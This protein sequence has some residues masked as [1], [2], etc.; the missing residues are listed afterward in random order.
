[1]S[2]DNIVER[3]GSG[4]NPLL[5]LAGFLLIGLAL[6]LV[7]F[8]GSLLG[9]NRQ[10]AGESGAQPSI[11]EQVPDFSQV[12]PQTS[13][14]PVGGGPLSVGDQAYDFT[15]NDLNGNSHSLSELRGR[16]V[17]I[18]FWATWCAP[19][20]V[21]MP[22]LQ[23]AFEKYQ[24]EGLVIL[25]VDNAEPLDVVRDFFYDELEL[26]FTPLLDQE[27]TV[28]RLYGVQNFPSTFFV[29]ADGAITAI[30]RGPMVQSQI[31][32]YLVDTIPTQG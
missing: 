10:I 27:A 1:M 12:Q 21:E 32:G 6:A 26:T 24:D 16:P 3:K 20:R 17:I 9:S 4:R 11:L 14:L 13:E 31:E 29:N 18:N 8:G 5:L 23:A 15:L 7:L 19:C 28:V 30:H 22:E 25:A 2:G